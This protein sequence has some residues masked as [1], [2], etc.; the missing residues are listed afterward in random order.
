M[1]ADTIN[2]GSI[3]LLQGPTLVPVLRS[4]GRYLSHRMDCRSV[5]AELIRGHLGD[6]AGK[7]DQV[8][9]GLTALEAQNA[10][11]YFSPLGFIA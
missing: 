4:I 7:I 3:V 8:I 9:P 6:P 2:S 5:Y 10:G 11:G 1:P